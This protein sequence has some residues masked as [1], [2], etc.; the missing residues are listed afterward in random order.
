[1]C[2]PPVRARVTA[3]AFC[4]SGCTT[5]PG[6]SSGVPARPGRG[7]RGPAGR[8]RGG[9]RPTDAPPSTGPDGGRMIGSHGPH[10]AHALAHPYPA[11]MTRPSGRYWTD[12]RRWTTL[13]TSG[14]PTTIDGASA[15]IA[16]HTGV[17]A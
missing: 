15:P 9:I 8:R 1:M 10:A 6:R 4:G 11:T 7:V 17:G 16:D 2:V 13:R 12:I 14:P 5:G 3:G